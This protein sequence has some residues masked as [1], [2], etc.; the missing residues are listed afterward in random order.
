MKREFLETEIDFER[1]K[2]SSKVNGLAIMY[3]IAIGLIMIS[4]AIG[5]WTVS[6]AVNK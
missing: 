5:V 3:W 6:E 2:V 4:L 1:R